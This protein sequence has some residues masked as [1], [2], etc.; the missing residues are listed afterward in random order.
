MKLQNG[1][2]KNRR[3]FVVGGGP[4]L[5]TFDWELLTNELW[6]GINAAWLYATPT[7]SYTHDKRC[8]DHFGKAPYKGDWNQLP[9]RVHKHKDQVAGAK[10]K[11]VIGLNAAK[12]WGKSLEHGIFPANNAGVGALNLAEILGANPIYLLGF[13]MKTDGKDNQFHKVYPPGWKQPDKVYKVFRK[14][15]SKIRCFL[16]STVINI[17]PGSALDCFEKQT[18]KEI[19]GVSKK[20]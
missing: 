11:E 4:S 7:I 9:C 15:F 13:D 6:I 5:K 2:W 10:Y 18:I 20:S 17:T 19:L 3:C 12:A 8:L 1:M 16:K 14:D